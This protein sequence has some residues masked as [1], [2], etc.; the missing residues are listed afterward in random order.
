MKAKP[1]NLKDFSEF[2]QSSQTKAGVIFTKS[3]ELLVV[4]FS[5][6]FRCP[7]AIRYYAKNV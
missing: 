7:T 3:L 1:T 6:R 2:L 4:Y 5:S